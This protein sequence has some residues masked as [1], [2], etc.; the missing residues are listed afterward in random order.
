MHTK[1]FVQPMDYIREKNFSE[2]SLDL[3]LE[4]LN[5]NLAANVVSNLAYS[6]ITVHMV[7]GI[8]HMTANPSC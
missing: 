3:L 4:Y 7:S 2:N 1:L 6:K 5:P 8:K